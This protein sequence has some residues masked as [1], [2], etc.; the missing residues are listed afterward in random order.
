[1]K[2]KLLLL[3]LGL[4]MVIFSCGRP[5]KTNIKVV[6]STTVFPIALVCAVDYM[7][8]NP[9]IN[10]RVRGGGSGIG[11]KSLMKGDCDIATTSRVA[12]EKEKEDAGEKGVKLMTK[13]IAMDGI[14]IIVHPS[15]R[16]NQL[17]LDQ[18]RDI[19]H[20][21][22]NNWS[23]AGGPAAPIKVYSRTTVSGTYEMVR[24]MVLEGDDFRKDATILHSNNEILQAV[25]DAPYGIG[26]IGIGFLENSVKALPINGVLPTKE[27]VKTGSYVLSRGLYLYTNG[28]PKGT[29]EDL[30]DYIV[31]EEGQKKVERVGYIRIY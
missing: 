21:R 12:T 30:I 17:T 8:M 25:Q 11:L 14:V 27:S 22:I 28:K 15:N 16:V 31:T 18:L 4:V 9:D 24:E 6:G 13:M 1:M 19:F 23:E 5:D 26:Y 3:L 20:G 2:N 7:N 29:V 10:V